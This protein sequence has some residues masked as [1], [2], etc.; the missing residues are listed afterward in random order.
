MW[1]AETDIE[2]AK[3]ILERTS[4]ATRNTQTGKA[5]HRGDGGD[6]AGGL[7]RSWR[8]KELS[9]LKVTE[10]YQ[11]VMKNEMTRIRSPSYR[12]SPFL[13]IQSHSEKAVAD[14]NGLTHGAPLLGLKG[15]RAITKTNV[16]RTAGL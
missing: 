1:G 2:G 10:K 8:R 9:A 16:T 15:S 7:S 14:T 3:R 12:D 11:S 13:L 4:H 6:E 5:A